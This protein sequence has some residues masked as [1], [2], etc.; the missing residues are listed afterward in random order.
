MNIHKPVVG[1]ETQVIY[2]FNVCFVQVFPLGIEPLT[3]FL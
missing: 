3:E 1:F 2:R